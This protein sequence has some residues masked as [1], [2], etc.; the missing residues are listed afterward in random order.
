MTTDNKNTFPVEGY[1]K[2]IVILQART[3]SRR[4]PGKVL[5]P[6]NGLPIVVLA[7]KRAGN[8]GRNVIVAT[9]NEQ[10][11]DGLCFTLSNFDIP[12]FRGNLDNVLH[13][14][15]ACL[16][17]YNDN[18]I[19]VRVTADNVF[20]DGTLIDL[21]ESDFIK[22]Q[23]DYIC[24]I[25]EESGLPYGTSL[26]IT[27]LK[28]LREAHDNAVDKH[29]YEHVMT[30]IARKYGRTYFQKYKH[31]Q[32]S[33]YRSTIDTFE[34]YI[35]IIK[36]FKTVINPVSISFLELINNL[37]SI[38]PI[39]ISPVQLKN[40]IIGGAQLGMNYGIT[41]K[42]GC[43]NI[44]EVKLIIE[45][46]ICNGVEYIDTASAYGNSEKII[47]QIQD[48]DIAS[49]LKI[50]TK[51]SPL[52]NLPS[53]A[54]SD[55]VEAFVDSSVYKSL[56]LLK[57]NALDCLMLHRISHLDLYDGLIWQKLINFK[58]I[59]YISS[60]GASV[61]NPDELDRVIDNKDIN[62]IQLP[63]N[64]LDWRWDKAIKKLQKQKEKRNIFVHVRSI[65]LQGLLLT[66]DSNLWIKANSTNYFEVINWLKDM[67]AKT[68]SLSKLDLCLRYIRSQSWIDGIVIGVETLA[69]LN[70]NIK[71]FLNITLSDEQLN[72]IL[73]GR[74]I[75]TG[76]ALDPSKWK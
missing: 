28:H 46:A 12:F 71:M 47:G 38:Y 4:L 31:L 39:P 34:D 50:I 14:F 26:E 51:L 64:I 37:D 67:V 57:K 21:V 29:D 13:R 23:L 10:M 43:V 30:Y 73:A 33:N 68:N 56:F 20:P 69:Q 66:E 54:T 42:N 58:N 5:L 9:S 11:D 62:Y 6:I 74:P 70:E 32:K 24:C 60:L 55:T 22:R 19:V 48:S 41:N 2:G 16:A 40:L 15:I 25:G 18:T 35:R 8:T 49:R 53:D 1:K 72:A 44:S 45:N 76:D 52:F 27:R 75:L 59:G 36:V 3:N 7:A 63:F 65:F 61:Q 17:I